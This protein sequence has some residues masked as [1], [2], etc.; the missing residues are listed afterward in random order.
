M[1]I[2]GNNGRCN[3]R[4]LTGLEYDEAELS[5]A[6]EKVA[7]A[8]N[9]VAAQDRVR[10]IAH[11]ITCTAETSERL[12]E[13]YHAA[14]EREAALEI[15]RSFPPTKPPDHSA[16]RPRIYT[17]AEFARSSFQRTWL[18]EKLLVQNQPVI[19]GGPKKVLKT[20][21]LVELALA[22]GTGA[23]F[24]GTFKVPCRL[25]VLLLSGESGKETILE[26]ADRIALALGV[27]LSDADVSFAFEL[28]QLSNPEHLNDLANILA[29]GGYDVVIIDPIYLC[30]LAGAG[31]DGA[32]AANLFQ[33][34]SVYMNVAQ[35]C[36]SVGTTPILCAHAKKQ[37]AYE[38][39]DLD[40][41]TFAGI[42]EFARQWLLLSR[43]E[44]YECDGRHALWLNAGG[45][46][47]QSWLGHVD[48][49]EGTL[50]DDFGGR[51]WD[52][53]ATPAAKA[54]KVKSDT[55]AEARR[56]QDEQ[57][58]LSVAGVIDRLNAGQTPATRTQ[59]RTL[60]R[61][62]DTRIGDAR[63]DRALIRLIDKRLFTT[64]P[65][66]VRT[67]KGRRQ[68]VDLYVRVE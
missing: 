20:G 48:V 67:G 38:P 42:A 18:I 25:R 15:W 6:A 19:M 63:A 53:V 30:L 50:S 62:G 26:T 1:G 52:V 59:I 34:G 36:L 5:A 43:R 66:V 44:K 12:R 45:S 35:R 39:L 57:D 51:K 21:V 13:Y 55:R 23:V 49:D 2:S 24:L 33:M 41:L 14:L 17:A 32:H 29:D 54:L 16:F 40:D 60:S 8:D 61:I 47:G 10:R 27:R 7:A 4:L 11:E 3:G 9:L 64:Q 58:D 22:L 56:E 65:G 46:A 68:D 37:R 28:P 31:P